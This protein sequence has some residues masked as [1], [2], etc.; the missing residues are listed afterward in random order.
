MLSSGPLPRARICRAHENVMDRVMDSIDLEREKGITIMAK[1]TA[2]S[3]RGVCIN[4]VDTP[5]HADALCWERRHP[6]RLFPWRKDERA[7]P[8]EVPLEVLPL[9]VP[10][11][12]SARLAPGRRPGRAELEKVILELVRR[13]SGCTCV[14]EGQVVLF[15]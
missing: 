14:I 11:D 8:L 3:F 6:C 5:G 15:L 10:A 7:C 2:I 13:A 4:I 12:S 9:E 1:N